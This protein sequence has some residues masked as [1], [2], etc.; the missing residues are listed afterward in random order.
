MRSGEE[1]VLEYCDTIKT[2]DI[3]H[4]RSC[5]NNARDIREG[6]HFKYEL[7]GCPSSYGL[8]EWDGL[9]FEEEVKGFKAQSEQCKKCWIQAL[10]DNFD[11]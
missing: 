6:K 5:L 11:R 3:D 10:E 4:L 1:I 7:S 2:H 9:C 8:D